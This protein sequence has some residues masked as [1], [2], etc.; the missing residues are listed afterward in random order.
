MTSV[1]NNFIVEPVFVCSLCLAKPKPESDDND[2]R[3]T[4]I[5]GELV[6][7]DHQAFVTR[8][9]TARLSW[10]DWKYPNL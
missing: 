5:G 8:H 6:C 7:I 10:L 1:T 9:S 4:I 2:D 3:L